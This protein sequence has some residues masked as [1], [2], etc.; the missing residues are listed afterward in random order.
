MEIKLNN[1][2]TTFHLQPNTTQH[3]K[4]GKAKEEQSFSR[5]FRN[6]KKYLNHLIKKK[7]DKSRSNSRDKTRKPSAE[8]GA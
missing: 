1:Y 4:N 5:S 2:T 7:K 3:R 8:R 6:F